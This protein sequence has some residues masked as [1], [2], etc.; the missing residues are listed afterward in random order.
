M[1]RAAFRDGVEFGSEGDALFYAFERADVALVAAAEAQRELARETWPEGCAIRVRMAVH[2]GVAEVVGGDYAGA[3]VHRVARICSAAHG[4]QVL[5]SHACAALAQDLVDGLFLRTLGEYRLK[6]FPE[7]HPLYQLCHPLTQGSFPPPRTDDARVVSI[8]REASTLVGRERELAELAEWPAHERLITLTGAGGSGKTRLAARVAWNAAPQFRGSVLFVRMAAMVSADQVA[9]AIG[10]QLGLNGLVE[11][12][13]NVTD[14]FGARQVL[15]ILDNAEHLPDLP[16]RVA[17]LLDRCGSMRVLA[18]SRSPLGLAG[19]RLFAV[20]PLPGSDAVNLV[21]ERV[22]QYRPDYAPNEDETKALAT[23]ATRLDGLPLALELAAAR[24]RAISADA[25][26]Q[27][28]DHQLDILKSQRSDADER[29]RTIR[30]AIDWSYQLLASEDQGLFARLGVFAAPATLTAV[31]AVAEVDELEALDGLTRLIDASLVRL[32]DDTGEPRYGMLEPIRQF[33]YEK[34]T[35]RG[36][37]DAT[38][39]LMADWYLALGAAGRENEEQQLHAFRHETEN[40]ESALRVCRD[41]GRWDDLVQLLF[42]THLAVL[43]L[44]STERVR[45]WVDRISPEMPLGDISRA[46]LVLIDTKRTRPEGVEMFR[47]AARLAAANGDDHLLVRA[48]G[49][50]VKYAAF[51]GDIGLARDCVREMTLVEGPTTA[52]RVRIAIAHVFQESVESRPDV[53]VLEQATREVLAFSEDRLC[54]V[55][56]L[57]DL[58]WCAIVRGDR[59]HVLDTVVEAIELSSALDIPGEDIYLRDTAAR[60]ALLLDDTGEALIHEDALL[61]LTTTLGPAEHTAPV[62]EYLYA[63]AGVLAAAGD[64]VTAA[65]LVGAIPEKP[66][67]EVGAPDISGHAPIR[68]HLDAARRA[69]GAE[70]WAELT[71]RG[72]ALSVDDA[73]ELAADRVAMHAAVHRA[74]S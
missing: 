43:A 6:D 29:Q 19:E 11:S 62:G 36:A 2:T 66:H 55:D 67:D 47:Q 70:H 26:A 23:I 20:D 32:R 22:R 60:A 12:W 9:A 28:L 5:V 41:S 52:V 50:I 7:P 8:P 4:G 10:R 33:A 45:T 53:E 3:E 71:T 68:R 25:L 13:E 40:V 59:A 21:V 56:L 65:T 16:A 30:G 44:G 1:L 58:S 42:D 46:R 31:A 74:S 17:E 69:L 39:G 15:L 27:R 72:E 38:R 51:G 73:L 54:R 63:A 48:L 57:N 35:E 61:R 18:T 49:V 14:V 64:H 24:L 37:H 34:L